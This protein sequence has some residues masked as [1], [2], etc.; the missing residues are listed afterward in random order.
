MGDVRVPALATLAAAVLA[1][2]G[3]LLVVLVSGRQQR[4]LQAREFAE[5]TAAR[6]EQWGEERVRAARAVEID[7]CARFDAAIVLALGQ[8]QRM[9]DLADRPGL[10]RRLFG[11]DWARQ[12]N[13]RLQEATEES[14]SPTPSCA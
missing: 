11:Q 2:G 6:R 5:Q 3:S 13:R 7:A 4:S 10:R 14:C 9:V 1:V 8:L 12:W